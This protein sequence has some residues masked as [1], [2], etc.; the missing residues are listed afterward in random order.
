MEPDALRRAGQAFRYW[1]Q[2]QDAVAHNLANASTPGFKGER[3]FAR[4]LEGA[5]VEPQGAT[6][7][8]QGA[9]RGTSRP[10]DLALDGEGFMVVDTPAGERLLRGGS[11]QLDVSRT[12]VDP[13]GNPLLGDSGPIM[14]PEGEFEVTP[15]GEIRVDGSTVATLRIESL[16]DNATLRREGGLLFRVDGKTSPVE[17]GDVKIRQG[18]LEESNVDPVGAMVDMIEI[19]RAY[20]ALQRSVL[21]MDGVMDR[22]SN[23][24]GKVK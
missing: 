1:E 13:D 9:M 2:K 23:D 14:L 12:V 11:F 19:Q 5:G 22:I 8:R 16:G 4:L 18:H 3:V 20:S 17:E 21:V 6:D 15:R 10:L 7:L 24:L